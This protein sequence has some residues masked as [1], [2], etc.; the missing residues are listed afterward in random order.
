LLNPD[1][2][3]IR[4]GYYANRVPVTDAAWTFFGPP[5]PAIRVLLRPEGNVDASPVIGRL[6]DKNFSLADCKNGRRFGNSLRQ[7]NHR[8]GSG[9]SN[10]PVCHDL[11]SSLGHA[12]FGAWLADRLT[13]EHIGNLERLFIERAAD[14]YSEASSPG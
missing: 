9:N 10:R 1:E 11:E 2:A 12:E 5:Y 4:S 3:H 7:A 6:N 13:S 14:R 8:W